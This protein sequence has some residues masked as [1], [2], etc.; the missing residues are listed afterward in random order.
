MCANDNCRSSHCPAQSRRG[1]ARSSIVGRRDNGDGLWSLFNIHVIFVPAY[2]HSADRQGLVGLLRGH[3]DRAS[4][5]CGWACYGQP[6]FVARR[7]NAAQVPASSIQDIDL[8]VFY[9]VRATVG[10]GSIS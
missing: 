1:A 4:H 3:L 10:T 8:G 6:A 2:L 9:P 5:C 7:N